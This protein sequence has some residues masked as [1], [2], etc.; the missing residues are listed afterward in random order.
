MTT[1]SDRRDFLSQALL[2]AASI[3]A[4]PSR[5]EQILLAALQQQAA[6]EKV[7]RSMP[8]GKDLPQGKIGNV[9]V[10]RLF[11][12]G[13]L[14]GGWA[15]SRD[16]LYVS[17]LFRAYN[18]QAKIFET[19]TLAE[20]CGINTILIDPACWETIRLY[21]EKGGKMQAMVCIRP[22]ADVRHLRVQIKTLVDEGV[23]LLYTHG[24]ATDQ[25]TRAGNVEV[26]GRA[27]ELIKA[28]G[29]PA[30]VGSHSLETPI[31]CENHRLNPDYYVKTFHPDRYWSATPREKREAW[32]WYKGFRAEHDRFHDNIWCLDAEKTAAFMA[33]V[34]KPWV[35][36]KVLAAGALRPLHAFNFAYRQGADFIVAGMFD[37]QIE[38]DVDVA[39]RILGNVHSRPR[40]WRG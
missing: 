5:E 14:I 25:V 13:N 29:V 35:A 10:S 40:P 4:R 8:A 36:F 19:L 34:P 39:V 30:G 38:E 23:D 15:H 33:T 7:P 31:L 16:L 27:L 6:T 26:L 11:L 12:G 1:L 22:E 37:F 21:R 28:E 20:R 3:H 2:G 32:C 18:T 9:S 17:S 24:E